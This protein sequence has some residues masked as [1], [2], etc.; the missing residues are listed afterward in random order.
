MSE[1][2]AIRVRL[3]GFSLIACAAAA[4]LAVTGCSPQEAV[5][6]APIQTAPTTTTSRSVA[7]PLSISALQGDMCSGLTPGQLVPYIGAVREQKAEKDFG[8]TPMCTWY[9]VDRNI[10]SVTL[11]ANSADLRGVD[12]LYA[13]RMGDTVFEKVPLIAA[14]PAIRRS[15]ATDGP[16]RGD[17]MTYV[18]VSDHSTIAVYV[19]TVTKSYQYYSSMCTL[20]DTLAGVAV[21]NLKAAV[22]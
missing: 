10:P 4:V 1:S 15:A 16:K 19:Q 14:Y 13:R 2:D 5:V 11:Y 21:E 17:C 8:G 6:G 7:N 22:R 9:A 3:T 18:A 20:T 12:D